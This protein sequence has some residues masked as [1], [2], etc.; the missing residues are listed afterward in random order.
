MYLVPRKM[1]MKTAIKVYLSSMLQI[2]LVSVQTIN[3]QHG[4][5]ALV[6]ITSTLIG[7]TW[8]YNVNGACKS[9]TKAK[10]GYILGGATGA[11]VSMK[12]SQ[13]LLQITPA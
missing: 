13:L 2:L 5:V 10:I 4:R 12:V 11:T 3:L 9:G 8:L 1:K 7:I 6:G